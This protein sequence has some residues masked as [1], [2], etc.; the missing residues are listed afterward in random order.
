MG[1]EAR[2]YEQCVGKSVHSV[3]SA[4]VLHHTEVYSLRR[5]HSEE[6]IS[7]MHSHEPA[8]THT[9][10]HG[11]KTHLSSSCL[12]WDCV[13][14]GLMTKGLEILFTFADCIRWH[15]IRLDWLIL[16]LVH[17]NMFGCCL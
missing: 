3:Q 9:L 2:V 4:A 10:M 5:T 6:I 7:H 12:F 8:P 11:H 17:R 14:T 13:K 15:S 16:V 1:T